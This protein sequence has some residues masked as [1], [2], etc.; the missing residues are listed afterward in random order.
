M[1]K[2]IG[3]NYDKKSVLDF[4]FDLLNVNYQHYFAGFTMKQLD[5]F[6]YTQHQQVVDIIKKYGLYIPKKDVKNVKKIQS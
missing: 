2:N 4:N 1:I 6:L 3:V 5:L